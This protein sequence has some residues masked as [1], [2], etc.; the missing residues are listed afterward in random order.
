MIPDARMVWFDW[1]WA[2][3]AGAQGMAVGMVHI[4]GVT[5]R[6]YGRKMEYHHS[7]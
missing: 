1:W 4:Y 3:L 7:I 5:T 6:S 2:F